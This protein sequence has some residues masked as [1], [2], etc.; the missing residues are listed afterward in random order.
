MAILAYILLVV[1]ERFWTEFVQVVLDVNVGHAAVTA[2]STLVGCCPALS[3]SMSGRQWV[4]SLIG[5]SPHIGF[6]S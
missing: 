3:R 5:S 2:P 1:C 4:G 6:R